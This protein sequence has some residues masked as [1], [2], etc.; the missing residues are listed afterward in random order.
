MLREKEVNEL[1]LAQNKMVKLVKSPKGDLAK[2]RAV[3]RKD[4]ELSF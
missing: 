4:D 2:W 3:V 1:E